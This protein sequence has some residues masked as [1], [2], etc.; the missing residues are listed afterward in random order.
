MSSVVGDLQTPEKVTLLLHAGLFLSHS[1]FVLYISFSMKYVYTN[2]IFRAKMINAESALFCMSSCPT[3]YQWRVKTNLHSFPTHIQ[4]LVI[5]CHL[6][7]YL[8][9][10]ITLPK[11]ENM[12]RF[13]V[14]FKDLS[15]ALATKVNMFFRFSII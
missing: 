10:N 14:F 9:C 2:F 7:S 12:V 3:H 8:F 15:M 13:Y 6:V 1:T 11:T 4:G 5:W